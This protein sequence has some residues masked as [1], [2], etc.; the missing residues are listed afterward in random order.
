VAIR[1]ANFFT[2][3]VERAITPLERRDL[4]NSTS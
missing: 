4:P 3:G 2:F 1:L